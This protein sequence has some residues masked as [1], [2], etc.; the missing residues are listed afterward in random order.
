MEDEERERDR[1]KKFYPMR[2][3]RTFSISSN[4]VFVSTSSSLLPVCRSYQ[5]RFVLCLRD[6]PYPPPSPFP[7]LDLVHPRALDPFTT[8]L[9][10]FRH[11]VL[12]VALQLSP[13][14]FPPFTS[15]SPLLEKQ[16]LILLIYL[17][18]IGSSIKIE[19]HKLT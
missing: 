17:I 8:E 5:L 2:R 1:K 18:S 13:P 12:T 14:L 7:S 3:Q 4:R 15:S 16:D 11:F 10:Q 9:S 6:L 19:M